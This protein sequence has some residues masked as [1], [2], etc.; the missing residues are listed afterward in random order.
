MQKIKNI[1]GVDPEK[2]VSQRDK[3]PDGQMN[4]T[5]FIRPLPRRWRFGNAF[6]KFEDKIF[7]NYLA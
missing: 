5:D 2:N 1:Y 3:Q 4:S 6:Q 7:S